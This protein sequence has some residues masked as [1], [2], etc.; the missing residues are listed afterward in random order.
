MGGIPDL[1]LA[2]LT[3]I[4][5]Y[6]HLHLYLYL[7]LDIRLA[8]VFW[9]WVVRL[10]DQTNCISA[11]T[12]HQTC[13][14]WL[15]ISP[16]SRIESYDGEEGDGDGDGDGEGDGEGMA[17][18]QLEILPKWIW[19]WIIFICVMVPIC[20]RLGSKLNR[21]HQWWTMCIGSN[22]IPDSTASQWI[23]PSLILSNWPCEMQS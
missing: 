13:F 5:L 9:Q 20:Y 11:L 7:Y 2:S 22:A 16:P 14:A 4:R 15:L 8:L 17:W 6:L 12:W 19:M 1:H 21:S 3:T 23:I 18:G 10:C